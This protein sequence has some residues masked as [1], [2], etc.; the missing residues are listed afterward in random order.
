MLDPLAADHTLRRPDN[1][2][3]PDEPQADQPATSLPPRSDAK[4]VAG[5]IGYRRSPEAPEC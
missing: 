2:G 4:L 1:G 3:L 5:T